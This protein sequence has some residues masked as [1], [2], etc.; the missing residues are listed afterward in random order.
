[1]QE[2]KSETIISRDSNLPL[3]MQLKSILQGQIQSGELL[4]DFKLHSKHELCRMYGISRT[5]VR[6]A[7]NELKSLGYRLVAISG[8][9]DLMLSSVYP[10][11]PFEEVYANHIGFDDD[12]RITHW[13]ATPFDMAGKAQALRAVALRAGIPLARCAFVGDSSNDVWIAKTAGFSVAFNPRSEELEEI[14]GA[15]VRSDDMRDIL[16]GNAEALQASDTVAVIE[17]HADERGSEEYNL[18]LG[19]R[20]AESVRRYLS[21]LGVPSSQMRIVSYGE[22]KPAVMG[23]DE[24]AWRF[25][26]RAEFRTR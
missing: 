15:V 17:G 14:A 1:M 4:P 5:V 25:N 7:L 2:S 20:R 6:E 8:T 3:W 18:A 16:K 12:G 26:R 19:E 13:E 22:S 11:H 23:H 10:D 9:L 24:S 21:A